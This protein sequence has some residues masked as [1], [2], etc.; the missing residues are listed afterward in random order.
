MPPISDAVRMRH[1][2]VDA[3]LSDIGHAITLLHLVF[4][5]LGDRPGECEAVGLF[6]ARDLERLHSEAE[7]H[8]RKLWVASGGSTAGSAQP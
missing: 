7:M 2:A 1:E 8:M 4:E 6:L 3:V 5:Q